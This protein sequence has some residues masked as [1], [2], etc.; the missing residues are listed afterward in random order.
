MLPDAVEL[1]GPEPRVLVPVVVVACV[2]DGRCVVAGG[3]GSLTRGV[4][5]TVGVGTVTATVGVGTVG[6]G[7]VG[8]GTVGVGTVGV[9]T[10]TVG[11]G[12]VGVDTVGAG[13]GESSR[14]DTAPAATGVPRR[15]TTAVATPARRD[16]GM[17]RFSPTSPPGEPF[18]RRS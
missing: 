2:A 18:V 16:G 15:T 10:E 12:A 11:V 6:V 5:G 4:A 8:V 17:S 9:G 13:I 1:C 3:D 7:T 14:G